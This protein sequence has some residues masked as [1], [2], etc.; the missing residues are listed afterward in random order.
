MYIYI[1]IYIYIYQQRY[2]PLCCRYLNFNMMKY[3]IKLERITKLNK[4]ESHLF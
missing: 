3:L 1:Y 4:I 2:L